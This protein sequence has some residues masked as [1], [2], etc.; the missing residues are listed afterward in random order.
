MLEASAI[1]DPVTGLIDGDLLVF[2]VCAAAEY[3]KEEDEIND[4]LFHGICNSIDAKLKAIINRLMLKDIR[5]FLSH[6][7][8][9][10]HTL[11]PEYKANRANVWRPEFLSDAKK[12]VMQWWDA[13]MEAGLEADDLMAYEQKRAYPYSTVIV[14]L[15]KD[16]LQV[17][18]HHYRWETNHQG[19]KLS[20]VEGYG[21][22]NEVGKDIKGNGLK[23]FLWQCLI[24]DP[25]DGIMGCGVKEQ[26]IYKSGKKAGETYS[27][28]KGIGAKAAYNLLKST[29]NYNEGLA[30]V[31]EEYKKLFGDGWES[32]L[33][34]QG[35]CL[36]MVD[37]IIEGSAAKY[38][39]MWS[40]QGKRKAYH[41]NKKKVLTLRQ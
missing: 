1:P 19:E 33:T 18:G 38:P 3:G 24:G 39:V 20:V 22:L 11:M 15:D 4:T 13:E 31:S 17:G 6:S 12:H 36:W 37:E 29:N 10:R 28:R 23:F 35:G 27:K 40:F 30:V 5:I 14:T 21:E 41:P 8:N 16:L 32:E 34:K 26:A 2:S 9:F 7:D 25:T